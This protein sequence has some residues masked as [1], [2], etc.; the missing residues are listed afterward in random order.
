MYYRFQKKRGASTP[1]TPLK[2]NDTSNRMI[3]NII[4]IYALCYKV[5]KLVYRRNKPVDYN[6]KPVCYNNKPDVQNN[7]A[8]PD[9]N[10]DIKPNN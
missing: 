7:K 5:S 8:I 10:P 9:I 1:A 3:I 6:N 2:K 4:I